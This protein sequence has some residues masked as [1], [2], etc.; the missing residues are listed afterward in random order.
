[1]SLT[2]TIMCYIHTPVIRMKKKLTIGWMI[3][4]TMV[5]MTIIGIWHGSG[6]TFVVFGLMQGLGLSINQVW[7]H[8]HLPMPAWLGH[9]LTLAFVAASMVI[10]R[11]ENLA[12]AAQVYKAMLGRGSGASHPFDMAA[13]HFTVLWHSAPFTYLPDG[14]WVPALAVL[15]IAFCPESNELVKKRFCPNFRW[16]LVL[17]AMFVFSVL[18]FTQVTAFLYF[19]F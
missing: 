8:Y 10:F 16:A 2:M 15:L 11:A 1:M 3:F 17:A 4:S 19:Q 6:G 7:K 18:H 12:Q 5:T 13:D 14:L 9:L